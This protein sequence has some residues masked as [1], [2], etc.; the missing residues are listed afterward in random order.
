MS[1]PLC[2]DAVALDLRPAPPASRT[3]ARNIDIAIVGVPLFIAIQVI[4]VVALADEAFATA[5]VLALVVSLIVGYPVAFESL[6]RGRTPGKAAMGIRVVRDDGGP[7]RFRHALTRALFNIVERPGI[8]MGSAAVITSLLST[9]GK[10]FGDI[11][12]GTFVLQERIPKQYVAPIHM[13][14][15]LA[16]WAETLDLSRLPDDLALAARGFLGRA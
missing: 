3:L 6:W 5:L 4:A 2:G 12:A 1:Q 7:I 14:P 16:R 10:R 8:T 9:R 11:V 15:A 13:P